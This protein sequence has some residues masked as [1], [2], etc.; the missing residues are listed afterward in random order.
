[1]GSRTG[2]CCVHC[3]NGARRG[4]PSSVSSALLHAG[5]H[6]R[7]H[8]AL[9]LDLGGA[10]VGGPRTELPHVAPEGVHAVLYADEQ[11]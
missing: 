9:C 11:H 3:C 1:M 7:A 10:Y 2:T 4:V 8:S 6:G 5:A